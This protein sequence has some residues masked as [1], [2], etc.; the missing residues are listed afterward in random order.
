[1]YFI[2]KIVAEL[3]TMDS[4]PLLQGKQQTLIKNHEHANHISKQNCCC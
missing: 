3:M 1:M 4:A 2:Q